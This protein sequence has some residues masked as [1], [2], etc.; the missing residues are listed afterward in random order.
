[1]RHALAQ[2]PSSKYGITFNLELVY[3]LLSV[4]R[5]HMWVAGGAGEGHTGDIEFMEAAAVRGG[6]YTY[7]CALR[8]CNATVWWGAPSSREK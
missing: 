4:R 8:Q 1:M 2:Q 7:S 5:A 3:F 6:S